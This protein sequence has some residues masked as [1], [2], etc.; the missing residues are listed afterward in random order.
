MT[1]RGVVVIHGQGAAQHRG[2]LLADVVNSI[3]EALRRVP[4]PYEL[5]FERDG[6][7]EPRATLRIHP[8]SRDSSGI[9]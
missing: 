5:T 2:A 6:H 9:E 1:V 8:H 3:V 7:A 4:R